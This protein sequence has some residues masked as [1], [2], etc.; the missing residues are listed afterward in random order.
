L[1][2]NQLDVHE[3]VGG[4]DSGDRARTPTGS[5][6]DHYQREHRVRVQ[7]RRFDDAIAAEHKAL[8][9]DSKSSVAYEYMGLA[10]IGK[11]MYK[12]AATNLRM[13]VDLSGGASESSAELLSAYAADGNLAEARRILVSLEGRSRHEYVPSFSLAVAYAGLGDKTRAL[14]YLQKAY[15]ERCD[16]VPTLKVNPHFDSLHSDPRFQKLLRRIGFPA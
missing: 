2:R 12:E 15:D 3:Q 9:L 11:K 13:A 14:A 10:Y 7:P 4:S 6:V 5:A 1:A 16:L 8:E